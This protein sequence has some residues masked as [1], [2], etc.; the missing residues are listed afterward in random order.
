MRLEGEED[1]RPG[2]SAYGTARHW[3]DRPRDGVASVVI[4]TLGVVVAVVALQAEYGVDVSDSLRY[5]GFEVGFAIV[6]GWLLFRALSPRP[7]GWLRQLAVGWGLG[8]VLQVLAFILTAAVGARDL[9]LAYPLVVG[10]P[11]ALVIRRRPARSGSDERTPPDVRWLVGVVCAL[12]GAYVALNFFPHLSLPGTR[13]VH[14]HPDFTWHLSLA[15]DAKHHWPIED[16][17][18]VGYPMPYHWFGH[19][20]LAAASQVTGL[21]L[22]LLLFRLYTLPLIVLATIQIVVAGQ[23]LLRSARA[24]LVAASLALLVGQA[25]LVH[26]LFGLE[27]LGVLQSYLH[28]S[29]SFAFGLM[30][31]LP[32]VLLVGEAISAPRGSTGLGGWALIALFMIGASDAKVIIL[33]M[34]AVSLVM[35]GGGHLLLRRRPPTA[36]PIAAGLALVVFAIVYLV[37]YRG[38]S[39]GIELDPSAAGRFFNQ[40]MSAVRDARTYVADRY[41]FPGSSVLLS[42]AGVV[43]GAFGLFAAQLIG[44]PWLL[45]RQRLRLSSE[46]AWLLALLTTGVT[47]ALVTESQTTSNQLY[48]LAYGIVIGSILSADGLLQAWRSRPAMTGAAWRQAVVVALVGVAILGAATIPAARHWSDIDASG[49]ALKVLWAYG[50]LVAGLAVLVV[51]AS[52]SFRQ[53]RWVALERHGGGDRGGRRGRA[54]HRPGAFGHRGAD[55]R[56]RGRPPPD[57]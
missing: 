55:L 52:R 42:A 47:V 24:G 50:A 38:H 25:N 37:Q 57:A 49:R 19:V 6:P 40:S 53:G 22:P 5:L 4:P 1:E 30:M 28:T 10:V 17:N 48:F 9:F 41:S 43:L 13:S 32:L 16:P 14:H 46:Q 23:S 56:P 27:F 51:I 33:P 35:I 36:V 11:A 7:G 26:L 8:N 3:I 18:V 2:T 15:G 44:I 39:S 20:H 21:S 34:I 45:A 54:P 12:A 31:L 29:P